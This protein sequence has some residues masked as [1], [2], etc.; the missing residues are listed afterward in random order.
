MRR[1]VVVEDGGLSGGLVLSVVVWRCVGVFLVVVRVVVI[2]VVVGVKVWCCVV[3]FSLVVAVG[4]LVVFANVW[5]VVLVVCL[6]CAVV[7]LVSV[8]CDGVGLLG[9]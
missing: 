9:Q 4:V 7:W 3:V 1:Y 2:M 8:R 6:S 5:R